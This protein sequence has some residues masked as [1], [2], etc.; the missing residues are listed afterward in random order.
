MNNISNSMVW[1][2]VSKPN[3]SFTGGMYPLSRAVTTVQKFQSEG[4]KVIS[5]KQI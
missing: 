1:I 2:K 5:V 3:T 4:Y